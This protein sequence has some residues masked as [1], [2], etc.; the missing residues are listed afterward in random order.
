V[1]R[2]RRLQCDLN[3]KFAAPG[4]QDFQTPIANIASIAAVLASSRPS[5]TISF[6][7]GSEGMVTT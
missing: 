5:G 3:K 2:Q 7:T 4:E 1:E 6:V